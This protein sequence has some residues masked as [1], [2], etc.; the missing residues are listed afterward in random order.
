MDKKAF[1]ITDGRGFHITFPNGITVSTQF[2]PGH[3]CEN[4]YK[5][6]KS[7]DGS[8][9]CEVAIWREGIEGFITDKILTK[10]FG[11]S[12]NSNGAYLNIKEWTKIIDYCSKLK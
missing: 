10:A 1:Q 3:Y 5:E 7:F 11:K 12:I 2:G 6:F 9:T 8:D 4:R